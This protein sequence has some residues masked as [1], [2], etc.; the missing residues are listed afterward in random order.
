MLQT[1]AIA[2][3]AQTVLFYPNVTNALKNRKE[4]GEYTC[5][6]LGMT[7]GCGLAVGLSLLFLY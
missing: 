2:S 1:V 6:D 4:D 7:N 3:A 5:W